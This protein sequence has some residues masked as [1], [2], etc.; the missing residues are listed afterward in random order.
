MNNNIESVLNFST[1]TLE[2]KMGT[3]VKAA[4]N[5]LLKKVK[6]AEKSFASAKREISRIRV[7]LAK[8]HRDS[9]EEK[10]QNKYNEALKQY[11]DLTSQN[12]D[13]FSKLVED[14]SKISIRLILSDNKIDRLT[15]VRVPE[16]KQTPSKPIRIAKQV[17]TKISDK[18]SSMRKRIDLY[19]KTKTSYR[20]ALDDIKERNNSEQIIKDMSQPRD[21][22]NLYASKTVSNEAPNTSKEN[23]NDT[24][25]DR[26]SQ[27]TLGAG[28]QRI[29]PSTQAQEKV[30]TNVPTNN[31]AE[32]A[33]IE[34]GR[35]AISD[36]LS[37]DKKDNANI[38]FDFEGQKGIMDGFVSNSIYKPL[39]EK[40]INKKEESKEQF[41]DVSQLPS[42]LQAEINKYLESIGI[43]EN[44]QEK[45]SSV[46]KETP[47]EEAKP[48]LGAFANQ[49]SQ[50]AQNR[51]ENI[52][53]AQPQ[54][55]NYSPNYDSNYETIAQL[56]NEA[57]ANGASMSTGEAEK[58]AINKE[59]EKEFYNI[60]KDLATKDFL[61]EL[62]TDDKNVGKK[63]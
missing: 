24:M 36:I 22:A 39:E 5:G 40:H 8:A 16:S 56:Y 51:S 33:G 3:T 41:V 53:V 11:S 20:S 10:Y 7:A 61:G 1:N 48:Y 2:E 9:L 25:L 34:A 29:S 27:M 42:N 17:V 32:I 49:V 62:D 38:N 52:P 44:S 6:L 55:S 35:K 15:Q 37:N 54:A 14:L 18:I 45:E 60:W 23:N 58:L 47:V 63:M 31:D 30:P 43:G 28:A 12:F 21:F 57:K 26:F 46:R 19:D 4:P 13:E 50:M 59:E